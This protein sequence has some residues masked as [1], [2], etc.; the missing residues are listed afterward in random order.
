[1]RLRGLLRPDEVCT[2]WLVNCI[3][4]HCRSVFGSNDRLTPPGSR[5]LWSAKAALQFKRLFAPADRRW[6]RP[7]WS[8]SEV[9]ERPVGPP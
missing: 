1:M 8:S 5:A 7:A 2:L 4:L 9:R 3:F 6:A